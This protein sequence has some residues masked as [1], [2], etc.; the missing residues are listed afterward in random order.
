[1]CVAPGGSALAEASHHQGTSAGQ[2]AGALNTSA[3]QSLATSTASEEWRFTV[4]PSYLRATSAFDDSGMS[5]AMP[6]GTRV[7]NYTLNA[8]GE[9]RFGDR[10]AASALVGW[11]ELRMREA[12]VTRNVSS[13]ADSYLAVRHSDPLSWGALSAIGTVKVPGTYPESTLT[14][15]KQV[16]AQL[17]VF[18]SAP[19]LRWASVV[20]GGGY[21]ARFG[22]VKDEVTATLLTPLAL[23]HSLALT[24]TVLAAVPVGLGT[25]AKNAVTAAASLGARFT[26]WT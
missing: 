11:Q 4:F 19:L 5:V 23:G 15:T 20:A 24:P 16:D 18:A 9:R 21:R 1:M 14:S 17:E 25:V 10:W 7:E 6:T 3:L 8:Y 2:I 13:V 26:R 12:G 22:R